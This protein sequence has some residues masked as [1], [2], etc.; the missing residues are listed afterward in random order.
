MYVYC[1]NCGTL[2]NA[3]HIG[4]TQYIL[5]KEMNEHMIPKV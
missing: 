3:W 1:Y 2:N 5:I 4:G